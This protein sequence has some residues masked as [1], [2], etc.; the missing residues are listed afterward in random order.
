M[1]RWQAWVLLGS[2]IFLSMAAARDWL[3]LR[4][5][6]GSG[7]GWKLAKIVCLS[8]GALGLFVYAWERR[9][10]L[11]GLGLVLFVLLICKK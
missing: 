2:I 11:L 7:A 9:D 6:S 5:R 8:L 10:L 3:E 1:I 4:L